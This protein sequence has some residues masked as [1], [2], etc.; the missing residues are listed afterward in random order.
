VELQTWYHSKGGL[1]LQ[2][3]K[4]LSALGKL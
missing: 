4:L 3:R 1:Q 2:H